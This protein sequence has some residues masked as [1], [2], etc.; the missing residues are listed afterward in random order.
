MKTE[1]GA[2]LFIRVTV[3]GSQL[4]PIY[5]VA[6]SAYADS[7]VSKCIT[8]RISKGGQVVYP[9]GSRDLCNTL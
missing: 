5:H 4:L 7:N 9:M 6:L 3:G 1:E 8:T 2:A